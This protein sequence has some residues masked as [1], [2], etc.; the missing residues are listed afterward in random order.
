MKEGEESNYVAPVQKGM[1][2]VNVYCHTA[3]NGESVLGATPEGENVCMKTLRHVFVI[4]LW[5]AFSV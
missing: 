2:S 4:L 5:F 3:F 1:R